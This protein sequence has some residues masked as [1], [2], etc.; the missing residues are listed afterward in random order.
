MPK[1]LTVMGMVVAGLI[2]LVFVF[3]LVL[4]VPFYKANKTMDVCFIICALI[5]GYLSWSTFKE[6]R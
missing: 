2:A 1:A 5:L 6:Q 3:D 4:A